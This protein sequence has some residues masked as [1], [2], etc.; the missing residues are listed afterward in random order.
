MPLTVSLMVGVD[1]G[2]G[3]HAALGD[4]PRQAAEADRHAE[5]DRQEGEQEQR[6]LPVGAEQHHAQHDRLDDLRDHVG[7]DDDQ[8]PEVVRVGGDAR[9]DAPGGELVVERKV[10]LGRGAEGLRA[11]SQHHIA[12]RAHGQAAPQPSS[13]RIRGSP[14]ATT[15]SPTSRMACRDR[16]GCSAMQVRPRG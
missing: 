5:D 15:P 14:P 6:Q 3:L 4:A 12:H 10:M 13:S 1:V 11:Q 7:D 2:H 16:S 8:L 9:D